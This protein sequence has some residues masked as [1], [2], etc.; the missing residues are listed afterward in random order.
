[1][2]KIEYSDLN[3][4]LVS[5]GV[6][7][8]IVAFLLPWLYLREPFDLTLTQEQFSKLTPLAKEI[9]STRQTFIYSSIYIIPKLTIGLIAIGLTSIIIGFRRWSKNQNDLDSRERV[10][11]ETHKINLSML[12]MTGE[13][14][15]EKVNK[16]YESQV[17]ASTES[18]SEKSDFIPKYLEIERKLVEKIQLYFSDN[19]NVLS[20]YRIG[21]FEYDII[22]EAKKS[23]KINYILEIKYHS[24]GYSKKKLQG[25]I[26]QLISSTQVYSQNSGKRAKPLL[27]LVV[28]NGLTDSEVNELHSFAQGNLGQGKLDIL[29]LSFDE[30]ELISK[31]QI[32]AL[33][34]NS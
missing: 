27:L 29:S 10:I 6:T 14:I 13:Q 3:K 2:E 22:L 32:L 1:M 7:I 8:I 18:I 34:N 15:T 11:T 9:I 26:L 24:K 16:E 30:L 21:V 4:F 33:M 19:Y 20:N 12:K 17:N 23:N 28:P 31:N 5:I 25:A